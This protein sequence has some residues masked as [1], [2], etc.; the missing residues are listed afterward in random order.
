MYRHR[1]GIH[2]QKNL[3]KFCDGQFVDPVAPDFWILLIQR[4]E[5]MGTVAGNAEDH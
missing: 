3:H 2:M 4:R 5:S 1:K